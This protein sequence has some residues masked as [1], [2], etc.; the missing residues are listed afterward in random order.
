M[1]ISDLEIISNQLASKTQAKFRVIVNSERIFADSV[2]NV[3]PSNWVMTGAVCKV[4]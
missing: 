1:A 4:L 2:I 3:V